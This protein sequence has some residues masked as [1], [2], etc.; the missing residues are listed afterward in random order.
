MAMSEQCPRESRTLHSDYYSAAK[1]TRTPLDEG[2]TAPVRRHI[3]RALTRARRIECMSS[4]DRAILRARFQGDA[5]K[6][7]MT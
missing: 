7:S 2:C 3:L 1:K 6:M 5:Q 4:H